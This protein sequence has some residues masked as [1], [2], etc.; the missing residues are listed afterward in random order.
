MSIRRRTELIL[1]GM[2]CV[3]FVVLIFLLPI[4]LNADSYRTKVISYLEDREERGDRAAGGDVFPRSSDS[5]GR[6]RGEESTVVSPEL[7]RKGG[8]DRCPA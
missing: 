3:V 1:V 8:A 7:H 2:A 5:G 6:F 4:L